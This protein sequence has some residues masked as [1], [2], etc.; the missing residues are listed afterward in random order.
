[1]V[2]NSY[3][4]NGVNKFYLHEAEIIKAELSSMTGPQ[5]SENTVNNPASNNNISQND[6]VVNDSKFENSKNDTKFSI[7]DKFVGSNGDF[8][9]RFIEEV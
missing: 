4:N 2:V 8:K 7:N 9:Q 6:N 3:K 1:M 5:N